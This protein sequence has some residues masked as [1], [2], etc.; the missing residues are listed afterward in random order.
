MADPP[1]TRD[2]FGRLLTSPA[3]LPVE[4]KVECLRRLAGSLQASEQAESRWL[5]ESIAT[6]VRCGGTLEDALGVAPGRPAMLV[7]RAEVSRLLL[8]L[9]ALV[10]G[11]ARASRIL[12][13]IE[14]APAVA[15]ELVIE[16]HARRAPTSR[17]AFI[18]ARAVTRKVR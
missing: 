10:G 6:W 11:D 17:R 1:S 2:A 5:G 8:R 7:R 13:G 18:R 14:E 16:L 15:V 9:S 4:E 3:R 12:R